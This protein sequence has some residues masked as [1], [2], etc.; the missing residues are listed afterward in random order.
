MFL[1]GEL[2][3]RGSAEFEWSEDFWGGAFVVQLLPY[4][5]ALT[6]ELQLT[7]ASTVAINR[8]V[9]TPFAVLRESFNDCLFARRTINRV[10]VVFF[11]LKSAVVTSAARMKLRTYYCKFTRSMRVRCRNSERNVERCDL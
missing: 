8:K 11:G 9:S 10:V 6:P 4:G 2:P 3:E 5:V 1:R 7:T